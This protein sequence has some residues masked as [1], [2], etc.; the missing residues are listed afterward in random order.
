MAYS[1]DDYLEMLFG[2][3]PQ[4]IIWPRDPESVLGKALKVWAESLAETDA[5]AEDLVRE[6]NPAQAFEL[7]S[8]WEK[9]CGLP[10]E[11]SEL[12]ATLAE[13]REAV[14]AKLT[15]MGGQ[16]PAYIV[17]L[18]KSL[19]YDVTI[20]EF[21][22]FTT[23]SRVNSRVYGK[24]W[25]F[26]YRITAPATTIRRFSTRSTVRERLAT[27]GNERL[28][29]ILRQAQPAHTTVIHAYSQ[30]TRSTGTQLLV[31]MT[32][33]AAVIDLGEVLADTVPYRALVTLKDSAG[34]TIC[35]GYSRHASGGISLGANMIING[36]ISDGTANWTAANGA[37]LAAVAGG[38]SGD[39][40]EVSE[41]G[42]GWPAAYQSVSVNKYGLY[43]HAAYAKEVAA[44]QGFYLS[45][46]DQGWGTLLQKWLTATS[47][48][49]QH[50]HLF[51][52]GDNNTLHCYFGVDTDA[53]TGESM[54][55]DNK[56]ICPVASPDEG[57]L[58]IFTDQTY[59]TR[60]WASTGDGDPGDCASLEYPYP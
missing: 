6:A 21:R 7:L 35:T 19:G 59:T 41:D 16:S 14:I 49:V 50:S 39:C 37:A 48:W 2:L 58:E 17:S 10:D 24:D 9:E 57:N 11:C 45:I 54:L 12:T 60:G 13:R 15:Q 47:A 56:A 23:R 18:A 5:R 4:G 31:D 46:Y 27:W 33:N 52:A 32:E 30:E 3:L 38:V 26:A 28:E 34:K 25:A 43:V 51:S 36:D 29:C 8:A 40:L 22:P 44:G 55:F 42:T 53:G 20:E 1:A